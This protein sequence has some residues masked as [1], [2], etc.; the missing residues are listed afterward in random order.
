MKS[1]TQHKP[2][3]NAS[4]QNVSNKPNNTHERQW[5]RSKSTPV[6]SESHYT[7]KSYMKIP[8]KNFSLYHNKNYHLFGRQHNLPEISMEEIEKH[9]NKE[10]C[11]I[12]VNGLV[13]DVTQF[14][15]YHPARGECIIKYGGKNCDKH[16]KF[17][18]KHAQKLF[19]K[20]VIGRI[21]TDNQCIVQ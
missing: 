13:L 16:F 19:F 3:P 21:Q 2:L 5:Y 14:L 7:I 12:I 6:T 4:N 10:S 15:P 9:N 17:H 11:W 20:F 8:K 18:A 1:K